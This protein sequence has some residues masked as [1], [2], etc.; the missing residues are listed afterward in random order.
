MVAPTEDHD[1]RISTPCLLSRP[2]SLLLA[3][4]AC[5]AAGAAP[6]ARPAAAPEPLPAAPSPSARALPAPA[7]AGS[8]DRALDAVQATKIRSDEFFIASDELGGRDTPSLGQRVA[9]RYIRARLERLGWHTG[10]KDGY[11]F[12]YILDQHK[13]DE[14]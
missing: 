5:A 14:D 4:S 9:A 6:A 1:V 12:K 7:P 11:F 2:I 13:L 3:L 10:A 8:L